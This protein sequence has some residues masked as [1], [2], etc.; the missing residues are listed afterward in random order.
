MNNNKTSFIEKENKS[1][2]KK[3]FEEFN[4]KKKVKKQDNNS[5]IN[6]KILFT[7]LMIVILILFIVS[8]FLNKKL[9]DTYG[10]FNIRK[11]VNRL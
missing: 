2:N 6:V 3:V 11:I 5:N 1:K 7:F 10:D 4:S 9:L 8:S